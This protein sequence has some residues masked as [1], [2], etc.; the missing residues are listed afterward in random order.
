MSHTRTHLSAGFGAHEGG[1]LRLSVLHAARNDQPDVPTLWV[2]YESLEALQRDYEENL[3]K[4]R[5]F[6]KGEMS[7]PERSRVRLLL[8][9]PSAEEPFECWGDVVWVSNDG[10]VT[11]TGVQLN[12]LSHVDRA[13]LHH[14]ALPPEPVLA[15]ARNIHDRIRQLDASERD[16]VARTG[17]LP[18]RVA[19][20]R[21]FG[22]VVWEGL[23]RNPQLTSGEIVRIA[24]NASLSKPLVNQI[25]SNTAWMARPEIRRA[26]LSNP[27][28]DGASLDRVIQAL[29]LNECEQ[30]AQNSAF[31]HKVRLAARRRSR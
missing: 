16:L 8:V 21:H 13:N 27:R 6:V 28:V 5:A 18:E 20:E 1:A 24:R 2:R 30:V 12:E 9:H 26:L 23:L 10:A 3:I 19:L 4:G 17:S 15:R 29:P 31:S 22:S 7:I 25:V 14:F 11:G